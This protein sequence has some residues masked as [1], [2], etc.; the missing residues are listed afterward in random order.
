MSSQAQPCQTTLEQGARVSH[1]HRAPP[2]TSSSD[3]CTTA[4][5]RADLVRP[6]DPLAGAQPRPTAASPPRDNTEN[7][8]SS[9]NRRAINSAM[10]YISEGDEDEYASLS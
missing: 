2:A 5:H 6:M 8:S 7:S 3:A 4:E 9:N 10:S 1:T